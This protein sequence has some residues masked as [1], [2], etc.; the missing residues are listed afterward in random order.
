[1]A[2]DAPAAPLVSLSRPLWRQVLAPRAA[3][4]CAAVFAS[5]RPTVRSVPRRPVSAPRRAGPRARTSPR[6]T[7]AGYL[8]WFVSS[9]T[10]VVSVGSTA[11]VARF[12]GA[13]DWGMAKHAT[14]QSVLL[15]V[16]FGVVGSVAAVAR[17][18]E[19]HRSIAAEG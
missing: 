9:Y 11:L 19:P 1:M 16:V 15:A 7:T 13:N 12:V 4:A 3:R 5:R 14:G 6:S 8:Y 17:A 18:A 10:V 2:M